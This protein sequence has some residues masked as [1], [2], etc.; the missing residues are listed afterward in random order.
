MDVVA[1]LGLMIA[2]ALLAWFFR[3]LELSDVVG[4]VVGGVIATAVLSVVG[5]NVEASIKYTEP[6]E[7][8]GL[9]LFSFTIG[10]SIGF[11]RIME[12]LERVVATEL[13]ACVAF[14]VA[15]GFVAWTVRLDYMGRIAFFILLVNSSTIALATLTK[16]QNAASKTVRE[17]AILLTNV[18]D[19]LQFI[20]FTLVFIGGAS[21]VQDFMRT[22]VQI[23]VVIGLIVILFTMGKYLLRFLSKTTF[24]ADKDNKFIIAVSMALLFAYIASLVDLPSLFGA[25]I[26][27]I[28]FSLFL[29]LEDVSDMIDGLKNLGLLLYFTSVGS[30]VYL[31]AAVAGQGIISFGVA[32]G[33][34]AYA[35]RFLG[36]FVA[37]LLTEG[38]I[39][40]SF[41]LALY[42]GSLSETSIVIIDALASGGVISGK[43]VVPSTIAFLSS[44][45]LFSV[46]APKLSP[47]A[48]HV[49]RLMP[50]KTVTFFKKVGTLYMKR[51]DIAV[52]MLKPL[53]R[54]TVIALV[55]AYL[56]SLIL[57]VFDFIKLPL[58]VAVIVSVTFSLTLIVAFIFALRS[59]LDIFLCTASRPVK[60]LSRVFSVMLDIFMGGIALAIQAY[61]F[62]ETTQKVIVGRT[63]LSYAIFAVGAASIA[64]LLCELT[65]YCLKLKRC[66][67]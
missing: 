3:K 41:I 64:I 42:L 65:R 15:A 25:F 46:L 43:L 11:H 12:N 61:I 6:L 57:N 37:A 53:I 1:I 17:M 22:L 10:T 38:T 2:G 40:E 23:I 35:I 60:S 55:L 32:L 52:S 29:P 24:A 51:V 34:I 16:H 63:I 27:G 5:V 47:K 4:Y 49:E 39:S 19:V 30:Q 18:E 66:K 7:W 14:W 20:L 48:P 50:R 58:I 31:R 9:T 56:N 13:V 33:L 36:L 54:F 21:L 59:I 8:L 62:Y 44:T 45:L 67:K 26:A 28:A